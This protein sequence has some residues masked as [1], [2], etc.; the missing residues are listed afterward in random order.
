[1]GI[2]WGKSVVKF[3]KLAKF[4]NHLS[5]SGRKSSCPE[6]RNFIDVLYVE[7]Q[8]G[9]FTIQSTSI[10][11]CD[12]VELYLRTLLIIQP[13][14]ASLGSKGWRS[15]E[16]ARFPPMWPGFKSWRQRHMWVE[17]VVGSLLSSER[18]FSG[19]YGFPLSSKTN[20]VDEEPLSGCATSKSL[21]KSLSNLAVLFTIF[22][23]LLSAVSIDVH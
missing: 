22:W 6:S 3:S 7:E 21:F 15:G 13:S 20:Q 10:K 17:F 8:V 11:F 12:F 23:A 19:Y 5:W 18:F 2:I 1:M 4:E 9:V 16:R 14:L